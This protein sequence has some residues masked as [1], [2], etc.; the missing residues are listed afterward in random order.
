MNPICSTGYTPFFQAIQPQMN[1]LKSFLN[2][3]Q[4]PSSFSFSGTLPALPTSSS[5]QRSSV[6]RKNSPATNASSTSATGASVTAA[7]AAVHCRT[8]DR[9]KLFAKQLS[10]PS[11]VVVGETTVV[12]NNINYYHTVIPSAS[13]HNDQDEDS[14]SVTSDILPEGQDEQA[15]CSIQ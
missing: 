3:N 6:S 15:G 2:L 9:P 11:D 8:S 13:V 14:Q 12:S 10:L 7:G 1:I 5:S 4:S